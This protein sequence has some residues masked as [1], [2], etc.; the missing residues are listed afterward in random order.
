MQLCHGLTMVS[1]TVFT[2]FM[3]MKWN[4]TTWT[5]LLPFIRMVLSVTQRNGRSFMYTF[6][7]WPIQ[8]GRWVQLFIFLRLGHETMACAVCLK[9][10]CFTIIPLLISTKSRMSA[11]INRPPVQ[12]GRKKWRCDLIVTSG[13]F[14]RFCQDQ[15]CQVRIC[16]SAMLW[17]YQHLLARYIRDYTSMLTQIFL[18][19]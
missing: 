3:L 17:Q 6:K 19:N 7:V 5:L 16:F 11:I 12:G 2:V 18:W 1:H 14:F 10:L 15:Q 4:D 9:H 13:R 8:S